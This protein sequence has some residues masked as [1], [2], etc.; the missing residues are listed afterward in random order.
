MSERVAEEVKVFH[1]SDSHSIRDIL[2]PT[3]AMNEKSFG[4]KMNDLFL[5]KYDDL[6]TEFNRYVMEHP[7]F[8]NDIPDNALLAFVDRADP[9]FTKFN[10]ERITKYLEHDDLMIR[11]VVYI[12]IGELAPIHS[13]LKN[14]RILPKN[15]PLV[16]A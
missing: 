7:N 16:T 8:L 6:L 15:S 9:E 11:P 10:R 2:C 14:P 4:K 3:Q 13:R 5:L 12:D 1:S